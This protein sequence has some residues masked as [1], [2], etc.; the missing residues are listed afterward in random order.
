[1]NLLR[2]EKFIRVVKLLLLA[3]VLFFVVKN[4]VDN[5]SYIKDINLLNLN[6]G[7]ILPALLVT[8]ISLFIPVFAWRYLLGTL[9]AD[10]KILKAM[11][12]WFISNLGRYIP[13]KVWQ[14]SGLILLSNK[15]GV[16][17]KTSSVS[18][19]YS[20][21]VANSIAL[22]LWV[23]FTFGDNNWKG[24]LLILIVILVSLSSFPFI[25]NKLVN[26]ILI[27]MKKQKNEFVVSYSKFIIYVLS[28]LLN[29]LVMG[30]AFIIFI[31]LFTDLSIFDH[32]TTLFILP[33]SWTLGLLAIFAP[34]GIGVREGIMTV[35][36]SMFIS[37]GLAAVIPWIYR[38]WLTVFELLLAGIF[39]FFKGDIEKK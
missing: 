17:K 27:R 34:G 13:G 14:I 29:W 30:L 33:I 2:N 28:Q 11:R 20:Q 7:Y 1:M 10:L 35:Y 22:L 18:V 12:I 5:F 24:N 26:I 38:I 15:E 4:I 25:I 16:T 9:G 36:L 3:L 6:F 21:I 37:P 32:P 19:I 8:I 39:Y 31:N 23:V